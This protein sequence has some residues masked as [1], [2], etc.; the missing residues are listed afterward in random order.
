M[1]KKLLS[2]LFAATACMAVNAQ[3]DASSWK[4]GDNIS[5]QLNWGDYDGTTNDGYWK[6]TGASYSSNEWE[7]FQVSDI[8]RYQ[9]VY[10]PAGV[11]TLRAQAFHRYGDPSAAASLYFNGTEQDAYAYLYADAIAVDSTNEDGEIVAY[12]VN[13]S[14]QTAICSSWSTEADH[15]IY[16]LLDDDGSA[17]WQ[18]DSKYTFDGKDYYAPNSMSGA[19]A[20]FDIDAFW[21]EVKIVI[22]EDGYV[23]LGIRRPGTNVSSEWLLY[24]NFQI[25]YDG[26]AGEAVEIELANEALQAAQASAEKLAEQISSS[27]GSLGALLDD[28][29]M[30]VDYDNSD[31]ESIK[32]ATEEV[33]AIVATYTAYYND[34]QTISS[35]IE[36]MTTL[37]KTTSYPSLAE[38]TDAIA[39][40]QNV[41][42][43]GNEGHDMTISD[44]AAYTEAKNKLIS[45]RF[46]YLLSAGANENGAY[47][48]SAAIKTPWFCNDE[49]NPTWDEASQE[50][51]YS[52]EIENAWFGEKKAWE[53]NSAQ[54]DEANNRFALSDKVTFY[55]TEV[56]N[57]WVRDMHVTSG[58]MGSIGNPLFTQGYTA[59]QQWSG[60]IIGGY[61]GVHQTLTGLPDGY[62]SMSALYVNAGNDISEGQYAFISCGDKVEKA[63]FTNKYTGWWS[64]TR[65]GWQTLTTEMLQVTG[66]TATVGV[67]SDWFYAAT[68]FHLYY[69]GEN[70]DFSSMVQKQIDAVNSTAAEKLT[71]LGDIAKVAEILGLIK[72][73]VEGFDAYTAALDSISSAN[74]YVNTAYNYLNSW[75]LVDQVVAEQAKYE[76]TTPEYA[77][78]ETLFNSV[79]EIG[80]G[81][82]DT[83]KTA[84]AATELYNSLNNYLTYRTE[85]AGYATYNADITSLIETHNEGLKASVTAEKVAEYTEQLEEAYKKAV[86]TKNAE[87]L[88]ALGIDKA[89][90]ANPVDVTVL[91]T[92]PDF[93]DGK[94]GWTDATNNL[95]V[96][97]KLQ[98]AERWNA[99]FDYS[100]VIYGLPEGCY[101][102]SVQSFYRDG[103]IGNTESGAYYN[104]WYA[105][106]ADEELWENNN[107]KLYVSTD[108]RETTKSIKS[109]ASEL[110]TEPSYTR[111]VGSLVEGDVLVDENGNVVYDENGNEIVL[112]DTIWQYYNDTTYTEA[113]EMEVKAHGFPFDSEVAE[114]GNT[115]YFPN[116]MEGS[117][118]RFSKN[119]DSYHNEVAIMV[120][121]G[122]ELKIGIRK[123]TTIENDW[124]L[125]DNFKLYYLG[126]DAPDAIQ[127]I[128]TANDQTDGIYNL[129]GQKLSAP[130]KGI[131]IINGKKYIVK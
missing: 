21:N 38:F 19:R 48:V 45:A 114:D 99:N 61:A 2:V 102:L 130:Q 105:S 1:I 50:Y 78:Y 34:A 30:E 11:Y 17:N 10:L 126:K 100:Q 109:I 82:S 24:S 118:Y 74:A 36:T 46:D 9:F 94:N 104:W 39:N 37:S 71:F 108:G 28:A 59:V 120:D 31:A 57:E 55:N 65:A 86:T 64:N 81:E 32:Q 119:P 122:N 84:Q 127:D 77:I 23:K 93:S 123:E 14:R 43:D 27:Y 83:Y 69:Y 13:S 87:T 40:A 128:E 22:K 20:Y 98:N 72:L 89:T 4:V 53:V 73:P 121:E 52:D 79:L 70:P 49:Y 63:Q 41:I 33:N 116:S 95:V 58:W 16:E 110:F 129:A 7:N 44:P 96:D 113:G 6:G 117:Y 26:D 35:L 115:Y 88:A 111:T 85:V 90:I 25:I 12:T 5:D 56:N 51:K 18:S 47:D 66:G 103:S 62:Y 67:R 76:E 97:Q 8:D 80:T 112:Y 124:C 60:S 107:V 75:N 68:G 106:A 91:L 125:F 92:N 42:D 131:N 15:I 3:I 101:M 29:I 54:A